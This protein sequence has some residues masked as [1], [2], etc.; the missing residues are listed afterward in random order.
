[1]MTMTEEVFKYDIDWAVVDKYGLHE[2]MRPWI[3]NIAKNSTEEEADM[4][5]SDI[6]EPMKKHGSADNEDECER[7]FMKIWA[8]LFFEIQKLE[9]EKICCSVDYHEILKVKMFNDTP[10]TK[11]EVLSL[12]INWAVFDQHELH[13]KMRPSMT[14]EVMELLKKEKASVVD[15]AVDVIKNQYCP[16]QM[17]ELLEPSL[18]VYAEMVV[19]IL[20]RTLLILNC[21]LKGVSSI[22]FTSYLSLLSISKTFI[23]SFTGTEFAAFPKSISSA[24]PNIKLSHAEGKNYMPSDDNL[25]RQDPVCNRNEIPRNLDELSSYVIDWAVADK[26][27]RQEEAAT[28]VVDSI[29]SRIKDHATAKDILELVKPSLGDRSEN[30]VVYLWIKLICVIHSAGMPELVLFPAIDNERSATGGVNFSQYGDRFSRNRHFM[31]V[32]FDFEN[33]CKLKQIN[34]TMPKTK[35]EL[36]SYDIN[37]D[38]Y[39]KHGLQKN[40][41]PGIWVETLELIRQKKDAMLV[42]EQIM[43]SIFDY[44]VSASQ[45]EFTAQ[46]ETIQV[47]EEIMSRLHK[48]RACPFKMV[49]YLEPILGSGAEMFVM[50]MWYALICGI[51]FAEARVE[52][53]LKRGWGSIEGEDEED[54]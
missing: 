2:K 47:F 14:K 9:E 37:W 40:M 8:M 49:E 23:F 27:V 54:L 16:S 48:D 10:K 44:H 39:E 1:M 34:G 38:V 13:E 20:W 21:G 42:D 15:K 29:V 3:S 19:Q 46:E 6:L 24:N 41:R 17:L 28:R 51:K 7:L 45:R 43:W 50:K 52:K 5:V 53:K 31:M 11:E 30:F 22:L 12:K 25:Q 4:F 33:L 26:F 18:D 32:A 35:A 36:F